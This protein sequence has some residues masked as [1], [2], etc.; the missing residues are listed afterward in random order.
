[1]KRQH[2][3]IKV[4]STESLRTQQS[5]EIAEEITDIIAEMQLREWG[6]N[7]RGHME[8]EMYHLA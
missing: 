2:R 3:S 5:L 6:R 1:M 8:I 4:I 7:R